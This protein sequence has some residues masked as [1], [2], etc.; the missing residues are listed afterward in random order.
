[1][2]RDTYNN[3]AALP[4]LHAFRFL[5]EKEFRQ[6]MRN[7]LLPR[8]FIILPIVLTLVVPL[9][10]TQEISNLNFCAIDNDRSALSR[11][12]IEKTAAAD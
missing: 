1:M 5:L 9:V 8:V 4:G 7:R 10:A 2:K 11:R 6:M 12:L 3:I